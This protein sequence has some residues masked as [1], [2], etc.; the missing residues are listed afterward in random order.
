M[1]V[2]FW[3]MIFS[4]KLYLFEATCFIIMVAA[5]GYILNQWR[6]LLSFYQ[7]ALCLSIYLDGAQSKYKQKIKLPLIHSFFVPFGP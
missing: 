1:L 6:N 3:K 4:C 5:V 7:R 2:S